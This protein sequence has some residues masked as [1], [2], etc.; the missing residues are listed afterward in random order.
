LSRITRSELHRGPI[1]LSTIAK[2]IVEDLRAGDRKRV[3]EVEIQE[4]M[5]ATGDPIL[6]R[7]LLF[8][9]LE[10]AFKFTAQRNPACIQVGEFTD[11]GARR[12]YFVKDNGAGFNPKYKNKLFRPFERLHTDTTYVGNG[13]GLATVIRIVRKHGGAA[14]AEGHENKG[15]QFFFTL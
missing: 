4:G 15:A 12:V 1:D 6:V 9:L 10:N 2:G 13:I 7:S 5:N 14:W 8:N 11:E 3:V